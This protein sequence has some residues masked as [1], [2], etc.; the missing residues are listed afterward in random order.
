MKV[1]CAVVVNQDE[2]FVYDRLD[3]SEDQGNE[4]SDSDAKCRR[5]SNSDEHDALGMTNPGLSQG[6]P[7]GL[8]QPMRFEADEHLLCSYMKVVSITVRTIAN[9]CRG[10]LG[11]SSA[12]PASSRHL[13]RR[14]ESS[15][16]RPNSACEAL[17]NVDGLQSSQRF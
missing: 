6:R 5:G 10:A 2:A 8:C 11:V 9:R 3:V 14:K 1:P 16:N 4:I 15:R 13:D 17:A 12:R 7:L